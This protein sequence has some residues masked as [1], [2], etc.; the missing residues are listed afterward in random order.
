MTNWPLVESV[1]VLMPQSLTRLTDGVKAVPPSVWAPF[2]V[3]RI[4]RLPFSCRLDLARDG[5]QIGEHRTVA[6]PTDEIAD[7][8]DDTKIG[9]VGVEHGRVGQQIEHGP[10]LNGPFDAQPQRTQKIVEL[11]AAVTKR[12]NV[13]D[14]AH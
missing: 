11:P 6:G 13:A 8:F 12:A 2:V 10:M 9:V 14:R 4:A 3:A 1:A 7:Q 5:V